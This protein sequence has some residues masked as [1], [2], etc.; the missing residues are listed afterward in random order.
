M[1]NEAGFTLM[2]SLCVIALLLICSGVVGGTAYNTRR[3]TGD[4]K[5][6]SAGQYR[7]IKIE[8]LIREAAEGV[9]LPYWE[10]D[11]RGLIEARKAIETALSEAG[12]RVGVDLETLRDEPGRLRGIRCHCRIDGRKY[13]IPAFFSSVP[14]EKEK[15]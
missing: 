4:I 1:K 8:R 2:E 11:E 15:L 10:N 6:R 14:L 9:L 7:H 5:E 3:I 13:E 12:Y